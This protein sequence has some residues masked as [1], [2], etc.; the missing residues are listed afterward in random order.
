MKSETSQGG[1][2]S[3]TLSDGEPPH[4]AST[5]QDGK[6]HLV[7]RINNLITSDLE[8]I[9]NGNKFWLQLCESRSDAMLS[10]YE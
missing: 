2:G 3:T 8:N 1:D 10:G 6:G 9:K 7:G 5:E 4:P